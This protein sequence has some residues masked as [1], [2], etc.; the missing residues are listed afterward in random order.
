MKQALKTIEALV[1]NSK[2]QLV[3]L[4]S[5]TAMLLSNCQKEN[6]QSNSQ[7]PDQLISSQKQNHQIMCVPFK[8]KFVTLDEGP[9]DFTHER[10]SG[11]GEG[12]HIG[13]STFVAFVYFVNFPLTTGTQTF[14]AANGDQIFSTFSGF[15]PDPDANGTLLITNNN[16]ITGGTG[17]F[18]GATGNFVAHVIQSSSPAGTVTFDGTICY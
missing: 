6:L 16:I 7:S 18:A 1:L 13:K 4:F 2:Y 12:T 15:I 5:A 10:I 14:T 8:A 9:A 3:I 11:T 17:R